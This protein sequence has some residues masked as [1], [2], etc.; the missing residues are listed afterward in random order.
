MIDKTNEGGEVSGF[1]AAH[2]PILFS[3]HTTTTGL[4]EMIGQIDVDALCKEYNLLTKKAPNRRQC[5]FVKH[6]G[7]L[8]KNK[9]NV[10]L[11]KH[12]AIALWH[13]KERWPREGADW[14]RLLD[15]EFPLKAERADKGLGE[16]DLLGA[17]NRG[18][19]VVIELKV[20]RKNGARGDTPL[21]ALMGGCATRPSCRPT[22]RQSPPRQGKA[23]PLR[24][25]MNHQ[26]CRSWRLRI[27]GARGA[28]WPK[29]RAGLP[30]NGSRTS[31]TSRPSWRNG[32]AS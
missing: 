31:S 9:R 21:C 28:G 10:V 32:S 17:T 8:E 20:C 2:F 1:S 7:R 4:A 11:E 18:R 12:L 30:E 5:Y 6:C 15:Y 14:M 27:G 25:R 24:C 23:M 26:S 13:L 16:I 3:E 19:L 29:E 22:I